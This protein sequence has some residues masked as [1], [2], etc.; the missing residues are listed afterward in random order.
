M[1]G[2]VW[3]RR[4]RERRRTGGLG[5]ANTFKE[6]PLIINNPITDV[7]NLTHIVILGNINV[8]NIIVISNKYDIMIGDDMIEM[9]NFDINIGIKDLDISL[10]PRIEDC[11]CGPNGIKSES[12]IIIKLD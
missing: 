6:K 3:R 10:E 8:G 9:N 2:R 12:S 7:D 4:I 11:T 5:V 1:E